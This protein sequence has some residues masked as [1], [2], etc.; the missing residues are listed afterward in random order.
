[1]KEKLTRI[2][3]VYEVHA[4]HRLVCRA[5]RHFSGMNAVQD[6]RR[7]SEKRCFTQRTAEYANEPL[8]TEANLK[9]ENVR[10]GR[11]QDRSGY[12]NFI[13]KAKKP[14]VLVLNE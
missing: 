4:E 11:L 9:L 7:D 2:A 3:A 6:V 1:M 8:E 12:V 13:H 14:K 10:S 5:R